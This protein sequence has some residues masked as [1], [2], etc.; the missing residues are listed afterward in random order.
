MKKLI[1][2]TL[3]CATIVICAM[4]FTQIGNA[5]A[6]N[7]IN[8]DALVVT[9]VDVPTYTRKKITPSHYITY[10]N[11]KLIRNIDYNI[12]YDNNIN[13]S[14]SA[15]MKFSGIGKYKGL[16]KEFT[17]P[18]AKADIS[19]CSITVSDAN[20]L[21]IPV[22][23]KTTVKHN[24]A[25][26]TEGVDYTIQYL[27]N[28]DEGEAVARIIGLGNYT[29]TIEK[30]FLIKKPTLSNISE[31]DFTNYVSTSTY[32]IEAGS[33]L[34]LSYSKY[35]SDTTYKYEIF[36]D[37][38]LIDS[39][40]SSSLSYTF[41]N[42]G[43]YI[44]RYTITKTTYTTEYRYNEYGVLVPVK[45]PHSSSINYI[46]NINVISNEPTR[47]TK[48]TPD[49]PVAGGYNLL[50]LSASSPNQHED[51]SNLDW[52]TSDADVASVSN[53]MVT[54]H[55]FG[56]ATIEAS[57]DGVCV[58]WDLDFAALDLALYGKIIGY[59]AASNDAQVYFN[60]E[61]L[62]KDIDYTLRVENYDNG[63]T[64]IFAEGKGLFSG[65]VSAGYITG[66]D[67]VNFCNHTLSNWSSNDSIDW[68]SKTCTICKEVVLSEHLW[69]KTETLTPATHLAT[70][71]KS[72]YC[73]VC[74]RSYTE[75]I[76]K[77]S[78]HNYGQLIESKEATCTNTGNIAY[79]HCECGQYFDQQKNPVDKITTPACGHR[80]IV[81][82]IYMADSVIVKNDG[83][84]I[85]KDGWYKTATTEEKTFS[86]SFTAIY[87]CTL[88]LKCKVAN[89]GKYPSYHR[90]GFMGFFDNNGF[91]DTTKD[92]STLYT[93]TTVT[94]TFNMKAG[95]TVSIKYYKTAVEDM[96]SFQIVSCS[97]TEIDGREYIPTDNFEPDCENSVKC[98]ICNEIA[99]PALGHIG[100]EASD[101][102]GPICT[103]C[104]TEY[105]NRLSYT[106]TFK[107]Y[108]G[109]ELSASSYHF[110][111]KV[112]IPPK[113]SRPNDD[114]YMYF[115]DGW[116]EPV[117]NCD[118]NKTYTAQFT[119]V[120]I[121]YTVTFKNYDGTEL[122]ASS[123][124][125]GDKV[126]IPPKPSRPNDDT[127]LYIFNGWDKPVVNCDGNKTY[128][129][130]YASVYID[131]TVTFKNYDGTILSS[132]SYHF[133]DEV[134]VPPKPSRPDDDTYTYSFNGWDSEVAT[135]TEDK[136]YIATYHA[137][138][139]KSGC[140]SIAFASNSDR[141]GGNGFTRFW[142][143]LFFIGL[144][145][146]LIKPHA[147]KS[148]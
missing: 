135:C 115:F 123:Y 122:S 116:N 61:K 74:L 13:A 102:S 98:D 44:V 90:W 65:T 80:K 35:D 137:T 86:Y 38:D 17:F 89:L 121:D 33:S 54:L 10:N 94:R 126:V 129:A 146:I 83:P 32:Y 66:S 30:K 22:K 108:D 99:K 142:S 52:H 68:H 87:D 18:I 19:I 76:P 96:L 48:L 50:F 29:G 139:T 141:F 20:Y 148:Q 118:G 6:N 41:K 67:Y 112:V 69:S 37:G 143:V 117:V 45:I 58:S 53:G 134:V 136:T 2:F 130:K 106:V 12:S 75:I 127:Y 11:E 42:P 3:I 133:G 26:L 82:E 14:C 5:L 24:N 91:I 78:E 49:I 128:T 62:I 97:Q 147:K 40:Q 8:P 138:P 72:Y 57:K 93:G 25:V 70:G 7:L 145:A 15:I 1:L 71:I 34:Q 132:S 124:H 64:R 9:L 21:G 107:N 92:Y 84:F 47:P 88:V 56:S 36:K 28:V 103:R 55:S 85:E 73:N 144:Y 16:N 120:Y 79:Y 104:N 110:G 46:A 51:V 119:S 23:G 4:G 125:F 105:G 63:I 114:T 113:P 100:G 95:E 81:G 31:I 60:N 39:F 59:N 131:Y 43:N 111:D 109:T 27:D 101:L 77:I 140:A